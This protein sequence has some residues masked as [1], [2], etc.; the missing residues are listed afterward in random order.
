MHIITHIYVPVLLLTP[1]LCKELLKHIEQILVK[2]KIQEGQNDLH[3][4]ITKTWAFETITT[5]LTQQPCVCNEAWDVD[6]G[7]M[8][9]L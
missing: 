3:I 7:H 8:V 4:H 2:S 6:K 1:C 5:N 9:R